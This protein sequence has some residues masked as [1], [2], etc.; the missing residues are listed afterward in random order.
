MLIVHQADS[1]EA[2]PF[3][4]QLLGKRSSFGI[5]DIDGMLFA[6]IN[7]EDDKCQRQHDGSHTSTLCSRQVVPNGR[8]HREQHRRGQHRVRS[9]KIIEQRNQ[10]QATGC[11]PKQIEEVHA[12]HPLDAFRDG[13]RHNSPGEKEGQGGGKVHCSQCAIVQ[14]TRAREQIDQRENNGNAIQHCQCSEFKID[15]PAPARHHVREDTA[16]AQPEQSDGDCEKREVIIKD[17]RE[18]TGERQL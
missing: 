18:N 9:A 3:N 15:V 14:F 17:D 8:R 10:G 4:E 5:A 12:I 6:V 2:V 7:D 13:Q 11:G 16:R 1:R